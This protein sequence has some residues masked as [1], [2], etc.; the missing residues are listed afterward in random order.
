MTLVFQI[1]AGVLLG[2][3]VYAVLAMGLKIIGS[4]RGWW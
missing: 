2:K 4:D 1:A 3:V